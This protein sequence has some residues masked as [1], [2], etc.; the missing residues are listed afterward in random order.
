MLKPE[1]I[2]EII[3]EG[4]IKYS[5]LDIPLRR[6]SIDRDIADAAYEKGKT[7]ERERIR[8]DLLVLIGHTS[9]TNFNDGLWLCGKLRNILDSLEE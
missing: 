7:E 3:K 8:D 1:E 2:Q 9:K 4:V 6:Q 5:S